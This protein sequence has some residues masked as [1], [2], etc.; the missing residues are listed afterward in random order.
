MLDKYHS[1]ERF[2]ASNSFLDCSSQKED[3]WRRILFHYHV[4]RRPDIK[5]KVVCFYYDRD[6]L[7]TLKDNYICVP[8]SMIWVKKICWLKSILIQWKRIL[9]VKSIF[10]LVKH[11][12]SDISIYVYLSAS[13]VF[14]VCFSVLQRGTEAM[15]NL[16]EEFEEPNIVREC[17]RNLFSCNFGEIY[18]PPKR[19]SPFRYTPKEK[20]EEKK[21]KDIENFNKEIKGNRKCRTLPQT[22]TSY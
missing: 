19:I 9:L 11:F 18:Q 3:K 4:T 14:V 22:I 7:Q 1:Y 6:V 13:I 17:K 12:Y 10:V 21:K 16:K 15:C 20:N 8:V 5:L 2:A